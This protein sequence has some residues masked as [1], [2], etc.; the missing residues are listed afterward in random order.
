MAWNEVFAAEAAVAA[1]PAAM[2][3][4]KSRTV[5]KYPQS[6]TETRAHWN[7]HS[8]KQRQKWKTPP[9]DDDDD[10]NINNMRQEN[11]KCR[12]YIAVYVRT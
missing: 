4:N 3:Y 12:K 11:V 10:N 1:S 7:G 8:N 2:F 6:S 5:E 9:E